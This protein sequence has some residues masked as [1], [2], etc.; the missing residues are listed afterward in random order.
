MAIPILS[1]WK[2]YFTDPH[3]G[4]GSSYERIVLNDL[5][6]YLKRTYRIDRVL[7]TP[8]FGFTGLSGLNSLALAKAGCKVTLCE[9]DATRAEYV[10]QMLHRFD[11]PITVANLESYIT[12]PFCD[13]GFDFSWNFSA[14]WFVDDLTSF[15]TELTRVTRKIILICVP[16]QFGLGYKWQKA[17]AEIPL[18]V[19][20][21]EAFIDPGLIK[22][23][24]QNLRWNLLKE[25]D[26]DCPLWPDIGMNKESFLG[27]YLIKIGLQ[28]T[29]NK[30]KQTISILD[31]YLDINPAFAEQMRKYAFLEE[32]APASFKKIW[33]HHHWMLFYNPE[34]N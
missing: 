18:G 24:M 30:P 12:M 28:K 15:L 1:T 11:L 20:F 21:N 23:T 9:T 5:L 31:Y 22:S 29:E 3:E 4:L 10:R 6:L 7:E 19:V 16:N 33:S 32:W 2:N 26:I 8:L 17:H 14:M 27:K 25:A 34:A 13:A